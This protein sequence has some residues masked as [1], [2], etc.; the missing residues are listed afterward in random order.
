MNYWK[1]DLT[2]ENKHRSNCKTAVENNR[3]IIIIKNK[4]TETLIDLQQIFKVTNYY[5]LCW[6]KCP[7]GIFMS[8][9]TEDLENTISFEKIGACLC[10]Y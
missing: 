5:L 2:A 8:M 6:H 3:I 10:I 1:L 4:P 7:D 9:I